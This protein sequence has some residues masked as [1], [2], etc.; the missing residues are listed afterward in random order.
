MTIRRTPYDPEYRYDQGIPQLI[1]MNAFFEPL[2]VLLWIATFVSMI[3][4]PNGKDFRLAFVKPPI[5]LYHTATV[6]AGI[7]MYVPFSLPPT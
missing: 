3:L 5:V 6:L 4:W 2:G 7:Q 1:N